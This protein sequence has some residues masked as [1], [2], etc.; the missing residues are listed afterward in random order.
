VGSLQ[1]LSQVLNLSI[2]ITSNQFKLLLTL[3][4][5]ISSFK[6]K[7]SYLLV[8]VGE[9]IIHFFIKLLYFIGES[10]FLAKSPKKIT[11]Q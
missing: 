7:V 6:F 9:F 1:L 11:P 8:F 5:D 10:I 3:L 4:N 2:K